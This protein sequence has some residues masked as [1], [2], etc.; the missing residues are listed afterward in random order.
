MTQTNAASCIISQR[1]TDCL[2]LMLFCCFVVLGFVCVNLRDLRETLGFYLCVKIESSHVNILPQITQM[3]QRNAAGC[4]ISQRKTDCLRL[5]LF[6]CFVV[7]GFVCV[8]QRDLRETLG[9]YLCVKIESS[10]VNILPQITQITQRGMQ[11]A[12]LL[13]R[14]RQVG[15]VVRFIRL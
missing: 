13:R 10:H 5:K 9:F 6:C 7:L 11:Q 3:T 8:N 4:I 14:E 12:A 2:R 1:K 15:L